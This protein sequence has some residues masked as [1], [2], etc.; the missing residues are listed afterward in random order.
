MSYPTNVRDA[1]VYLVPESRDI[2]LA[3]FGE[4]DDRGYILRWDESLGPVPTEEQ[5][6]KA[7]AELAT[8]TPM[9]LAAIERNLE[10][11]RNPERA[12][13]RAAI[14]ADIQTIDDY[15]ALPT[16]TNA[17]HFA[18]MRHVSRCM[19]RVLRFIGRELLS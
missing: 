13:L 4:Q 6:E 15:F 14:V 1:C 18:Q 8:K 2:S 10:A 17:Q 5:V 9:E 12:E 16:P 7:F 3:C 19:R 11:K